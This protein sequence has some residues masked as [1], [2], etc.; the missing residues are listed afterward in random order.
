[1]S[2]WRALY[3]YKARSRGVALSN[4]VVDVLPITADARTR[5]FD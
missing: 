4:Y 5:A 3:L 1:M 2:T